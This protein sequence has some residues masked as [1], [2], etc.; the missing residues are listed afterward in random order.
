[1]DKIAVDQR[2]VEQKEFYQRQNS[3]RSKSS[4]TKIIRYKERSDRK[5]SIKEQS[6]KKFK[7][8]IFSDERWSYKHK[9]Q[10]ELNSSFPNR[11]MFANKT[12][13]IFFS[14]PIS[15]PVSHQ[16]GGG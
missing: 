1:L 3:S 2:G 6:N 15:G 8:I 14:C 7:C 16:E 5:H 12:E 13:S 11:E 9:G 10:T 4:R